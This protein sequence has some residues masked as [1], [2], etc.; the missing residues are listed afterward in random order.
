MY[1]VIL[2]VVHRVGAGE[3]G[4]AIEGTALCFP[5]YCMSSLQ[6]CQCSSIY[7]ACPKK[8]KKAW[9]IYRVGCM[10]KENTAEKKNWELDF[11]F[12][13]RAVRLTV[14]LVPSNSWK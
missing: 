12:L 8:K 2:V 3:P 14:Y 4:P 9:L 10:E 11:Y 6:S 5:C 1:Q 7:S 13:L